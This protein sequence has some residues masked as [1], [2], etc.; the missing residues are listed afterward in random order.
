MGAGVAV[1]SEEGEGADNQLASA[2][3]M[4][5]ALCRSGFSR[6]SA[7]GVRMVV[8]QGEG[9][10]ERQQEQGVLRMGMAMRVALAYAGDRSSRCAARGCSRVVSQTL[11]HWS[12][13]AHAGGGSPSSRALPYSIR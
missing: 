6:L 11:R 8:G 10:G 2:G 3:A 9:D 13:G 7:G 12:R 1:E 4:W 5:C